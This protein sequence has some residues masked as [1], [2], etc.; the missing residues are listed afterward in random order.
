MIG[1]PVVEVVVSAGL[2]AVVEVAPAGSL[3]EEVA[4]DES[5]AQP[6]STTAMSATSRTRRQAALKVVIGDAELH[7]DSSGNMAEWEGF[8][9]S[10]RVTPAYT[11]SS[12]AP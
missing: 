10:R 2:D 8:E 11:I 5:P 6:E 12:R 3:E 7:S 4:L 9:P 1:G